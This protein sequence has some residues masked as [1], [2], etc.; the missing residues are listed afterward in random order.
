MTQVQL[1]PDL[2][3]PVPAA[4]GAD[5]RERLRLVV[6]DERRVVSA[7]V[8]DLAAL[9]TPADL[10]DALRGAFTVADGARGAASLEKAGRLEEYLRR[11]EATLEGRVRVQPPTP[12]DTSRE[13]SRRR[14]E[15]RAAAGHRRPV[16]PPPPPVTSTNGYLTVQRAADGL[17]LSVEVDAAWLSAARPQH[18]ERAIVEACRFGGLR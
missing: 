6:D 10:E 9:R 12:P 3:R 15:A 1:D 18:L 7:E 16:V 4:A 14:R 8:L 5:L 11:A 17:L 2:F 13:A